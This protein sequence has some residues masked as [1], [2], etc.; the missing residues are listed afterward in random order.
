MNKTLKIILN[1]AI[2]ALIG[3]F[4]YFIAQSINKNDITYVSIP[5]G[6][7][8]R[9]NSP[10]KL[11]SSF[12][13]SGRIE[14]FELSGDELIVAISDSVFIYKQEGELANKFGV[15]G[16]IRDIATNGDVIYLLF[17][18]RIELYDK[19]GK[20]LRSWEACSE[21]SDYCSFTLADDFVFVTDAGNKN[22]CKYTKTGDFVQF[23]QSP[24]GFIVPS[25][26]F[27]ITYVKGIIYC[28]NPGRHRVESYSIN[29]EYI[30]SFG[31][32]G[33]IAGT[34]GGCCNPVHLAGTS[35]G[36]IITSEKGNPRISC[37][38]SSGEFR[39]VMLDSEAL[40]GGNYAYDVKIYNDKLFVAGRNRVSTFK[41]DTTPA[42]GTA[43]SSCG[44][45][46]PLRK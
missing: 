38:G 24:D 13:A 29:G 37:Y 44:V 36:E 10:Y 19:S 26:S 32:A 3:G 20:W 9:S 31:Q 5:D 21:L 30:A 11:I 12:N 33:A 42:Q 18:T 14:A 41:Y 1:T 46:C 45:D 6:V 28:S 35:A 25:Y 2:F 23:I 43:C 15:G 34:F 40:G 22:I 7:E 27:G 8:V 16:N 39:S 4:I 17:A